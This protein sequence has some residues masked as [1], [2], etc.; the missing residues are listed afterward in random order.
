MRSVTILRE[1]MRS[2]RVGRPYAMEMVDIVMLL[3]VTAA[4]GV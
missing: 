2:A 4:E 3:S 1:K